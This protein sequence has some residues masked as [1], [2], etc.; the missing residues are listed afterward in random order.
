MYVFDI[1]L[2]CEN[3][4]KIR[5]RDYKIDKV[6]FF[7]GSGKIVILVIYDDVKLFYN[8]FLVVIIEGKRICWNG[9][10]VFLKENFCEVWS[11]KGNIKII[12]DKNE[13]FVENILL[14][15]LNVI[16]WF[17]VK[18]NSIEMD[19]NYIDFKFVNGNVY[20]F[21]NYKKEFENWF[22]KEFLRD[23]LEILL[24]FYL[25]DEIYFD[26]NEIFEDEKEVFKDLFWKIERKGIFL[27][28]YKD[29]FLKLIIWFK[30]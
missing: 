20:L 9:S 7:D 14:E 19:E 2:D 12:N 18:K 11:W 25:L 6:G 24:I 23:I 21:L 3:E 26:I 28:Y 13:V 10:G 29:Y 8:G 5:F 15:K 22:R 1:V 4:N 27:K 16:D 17:L 30:N